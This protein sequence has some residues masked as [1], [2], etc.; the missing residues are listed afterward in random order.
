MQ[1]TPQTE[2]INPTSPTCAGVSANMENSLTCEVSGN[3]V[4]V[5]LNFLASNGD[6]LVSGSS[7]SFSVSGYK[8]PSNTDPPTSN[9]AVLTVTADS[10]ANV[11]QY[12]GTL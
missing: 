4:I 10:A 1:L 11:A 7:F 5:T 3:I 12:T 6:E 8:N 9:F 2:V